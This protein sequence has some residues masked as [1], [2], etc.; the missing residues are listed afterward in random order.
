MLQ[1][2]ERAAAPRIT[3]YPPRERRVYDATA[4]DPRWLG[5][6]TQALKGYSINNP[7]LT[8]WVCAA[9][10]FVCRLYHHGPTSDEVG[11]RENLTPT[12]SPERP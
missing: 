10:P 1:P 9:E 11:M 4:Y 3:A 6:D 7:P 2:T 8:R 5:S 12:R